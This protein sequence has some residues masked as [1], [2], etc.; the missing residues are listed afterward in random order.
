MT[1][2]NKQNTALYCSIKRQVHLVGTGNCG[3]TW[4]V[5]EK[6]VESHGRSW[7]IMCSVEV[8][9][10][11]S[12]S[13]FS[14]NGYS[15]SV[16]LSWKYLGKCW[17]HGDNKS[18]NICNPLESGKYLQYGEVVVISE[19]KTRRG[20]IGRGRN[21]QQKIWMWKIGVLGIEAVS[22][23]SKWNI[24]ISFTTRLVMSVGELEALCFIAGFW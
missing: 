24:L 7:G 16:S 1:S 8:N 15:V 18:N 12:Y 6:P 23:Q 14:L 13:A 9:N 21:I 2:V 5:S 17:S 3:K 10:S 20:I 19:A 22:F 11:H 4:W